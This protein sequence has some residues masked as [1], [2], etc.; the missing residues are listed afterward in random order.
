M[1]HFTILELENSESPMIGT[2]NNVTDDKIGILSF[3]KRL[4]K[5]L[6]THFDVMF[7]NFLT[8]PNLNSCLS[9]KDINI[10]IN[11]SFYKIRIL[12]TWIY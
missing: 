5:A 4:I 6:E 9:H 12:E 3:E 2:I 11:N 10:E 1:K 8:I 7:I